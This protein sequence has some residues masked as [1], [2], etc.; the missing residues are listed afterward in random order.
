MS[1][2]DRA[3]PSDVAPLGAT[4]D[5]SSGFRFRLWAPRANEAEVEYE[6]S[7]RRVPLSTVG[8]AGYFEGRDPD[9]TAGD[10]YW[11][12]LDDRRYADPASRSQPDGSGGPSELVDLT[13]YG[14]VRPL[15]AAMDL[16]RSA[17]YEMHV[18]TF[19][20]P[21]TFEAAI[22]HLAEIER[23]GVTAVELLPVAEGGGE[24][25]WGYGGVYQFAPRRA[26]GGPAGLIRFVDAAHRAGLAVLLDV[27][28]NHWGPGSDFLEEFGPYFHPNASTPWGPTPNLIAAGSDEVRN[29]FHENG[30][31]WVEEYGVDGFRLDA[32]HEI[33]D[34]APH[35]FWAEFSNEM[36][37][38]GR[39]TGRRPVLIAES[40]LN[41]ASILRPTAS[42]GWGLDAQWTD[43]FHHALHA[44]LTGE[45]GGY[46][47]DYGSLEILARAFER[48]FVFEGQFS[49]AKG[50]RH[51]A[52]SADALP[53]QFV[54][55]DQNHDQVGNRSDGARMTTLVAPPLVRVALAMT[56]LSPYVP[57]LFMGEEFGETR[58][59]YFFGDP[60][61]EARARLAEGRRRH[62]LE[63]GFDAPAPDPSE[64]ATFEASRLDWARSA[65][66]AGRER[67]EFVRSLLALRRARAGWTE[68]G[69]VET[70]FSE[71]ERWLAVRRVTADSRT[72]LLVN[73]A[74]SPRTFAGLPWADRWRTLFQTEPGLPSTEPWETGPDASGP[75][76]P[77]GSARFSTREDS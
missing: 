59:F 22:D 43:D 20:D 9:A 29:Y 62:L 56:L 13:V 35:R 21:G 65:S 42:G 45:R 51:G 27:V 55:F 54:V 34:R 48:P 8:R 72:L 28:Y 53:S 32:V 18:G 41:D 33:Y 4:P 64:L 40:D 2:A 71:T 36:R 19:T 14:G 37:A 5:R 68:P 44:A 69:S 66:V 77:P 3:E 63:N 15:A 52:S 17:I 11:V 10:R 6:R 76:L 47:A 46:Y 30:R 38:V 50:R 23:S 16:A 49:E 26:Y 7:G 57:M 75:E 61:P 73:L 60:P 31:M 74:S 12:R 67:R 24:R 70:R 39:R 58:P 1:G 25:G